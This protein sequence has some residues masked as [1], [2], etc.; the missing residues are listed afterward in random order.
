MAWKDHLLE[1]IMEIYPL[2]IARK[3]KKIND[4]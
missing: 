2:E 4:C 3:V 1:K